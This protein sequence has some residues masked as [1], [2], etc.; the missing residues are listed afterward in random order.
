MTRFDHSIQFIRRG[1]SLL[2]TVLVVCIL[3]TIAAIAMPRYVD[4]L[5]FYRA[6]LAA[7][8]IAADLA[9]ARD[10][11]WTTGARQVVTFD[12]NTHEYRLPG[13]RSLERSTAEYVVILSK[14]PYDAE[15]IS[16]DF[17]GQSNVTFDGYGLPDRSGQV[18]VKAGSF[19]KTI[20]LDGNT[21]DAKVQ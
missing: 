15:I 19:Q 21:G 10:H 20:V 17:Q 11:A 4:S 14:A 7:K 5:N 12:P 9:M 18:V 16:A 6:D 8:R 13:I 2:E 3:G 1:F